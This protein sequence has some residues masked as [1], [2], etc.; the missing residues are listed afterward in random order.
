MST[1]LLFILIAL[2]TAYQMANAETTDIQRVSLGTGSVQGDAASYYLSFSEDASVIAFE[3]FNTNWLPDQV[4]VNFVDIFVRDRV[5]DT[6]IKISVTPGGSPSDQRSFDPTVSA[7]GRYV[8][9][10][11][12]ATNLV[13]HD[14]NRHD[15]SDDGLDV[16]LY[17][18][19]LRTLQRV[20]LDWMGEQ[21]NR[22]SVGGITP[23]GRYAIF[24]SNGDQ[25]AQ[26]DTNSQQRSAIYKRNLQTGAIERITK[27]PNGEY[28]NGGVGGAVSSYDGR[29]IVYITDATNLVANDANGVTDV[30]LFDS[31]TKQ[32]ML[33]SRPIGGGQSNGMSSPTSI[34]SDGRYITF[35]SAATNLVPGDTNGQSDI[36]VYDRITGDLE[37]V[38]ISSSGQLSNGESKDPGICG[39]GRFV[40]FTSD[41]TSLVSQPPNG[42]RQI[43]VHD[44][45][46]HETFLASVNSS[47]ELGNGRGHRGS[48]SSDCS[49]VGFATDAS[50]IVPNDT[51]GSRDLFAARIMYPADL[52][53]SS[54]T[55]RGNFEP[56]QTISYTITLRNSGTETVA[57]SLTNPIPSDTTYVLSSLAVVGGSY[58]GALNRIEWNGNIPGESEVAFTYAVVI[59]AGVPDFILITNEASLSGDG[60]IHAL[61][62]VGMVNGLKTY[63]PI[64]AQN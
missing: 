10:N 48:L 47:G 4:G 33:V 51:N 14:T 26:N 62:F 12:Y 34:S 3:S 63:F 44:R 24:T 55:A 32:T 53:A 20:S 50:N 1:L 38:S 22:N 43:Y 21:I 25:V 57:A 30:L 56:G 17:D 11:S 58:N 41:G 2:F 28:P 61:E 9:F 40:V 54:M 27:G 45:L 39:D 29:Y 52:S 35:R 8:A 15:Y 23:D 19:Q 7:N 64:M 60:Q 37:M 5:T 36:F 49:T 59:D 18:R 6:T 46:R 31:V 42:Q 16:F 13:P